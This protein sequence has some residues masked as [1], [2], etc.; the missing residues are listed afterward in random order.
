MRSPVVLEPINKKL[1]WHVVSVVE[2]EALW[3]NLDELFQYLFLR[4]V[5]NY[6]MLGVDWQD[7]KA[8]RNATRLFLLLLFEP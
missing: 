2:V 8:I 6:D 1:E 4:N 7:G 3:P 5:T